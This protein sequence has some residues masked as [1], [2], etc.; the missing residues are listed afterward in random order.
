MATPDYTAQATALL[1]TCR[2]ESFGTPEGWDKPH[3][4]IDLIDELSLSIDVGA[5]DEASA[6]TDSNVVQIVAAKLERDATA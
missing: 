3:F 4:R 6:R 5:V 1:A 2:V